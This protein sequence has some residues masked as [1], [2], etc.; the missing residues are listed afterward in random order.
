MRLLSGGDQSF[1]EAEKQEARM[2]CPEDNMV[3]KALTLFLGKEYYWGPSC[4][5]STKKSNSHTTGKK[6]NQPNITG[7]K[8]LCSHNDTIMKNGNMMGT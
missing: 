5:Y 6:N 4:G 3:Q 7:I 1:R 8:I 2:N